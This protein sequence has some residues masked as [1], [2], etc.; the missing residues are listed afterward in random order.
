[1]SNSNTTIT[2]A[3]ENSDETQASQSFPKLIIICAAFVTIL[4]L[5]WIMFLSFE[6]RAIL[7]DIRDE[8]LY[9]EELRG[10]IMVNDEILSSSAR[11][12]VLTNDPI[13]EERYNKYASKL[14]EAL[15]KAIEL[16]PNGLSVE[17]AKKTHD[18]NHELIR[19]EETA[20]KL[21]QE[22]KTED[23]VAVLFSAEYSTQKE[24]Y[25]SG[26]LVFSEELKKLSI[27]QIDH[28]IKNAKIMIAITTCV[29]LFLIAVWCIA[30]RNIQGWQN[31][32]HFAR[33]K[34]EEAAQAKSAFL[35]NTSHEIRTPMNGIIGMTDILKDTGLNKDQLQY[36]KTISDSCDALLTIT[37]DILDF[38]KVEAGH[39]SL[40]NDP[41]NLEAALEDIVALLSQKAREK[42]LDF[43]L[44]YDPSIPKNFIGDV[45][46]LRQIITNITGNAIKFTL[47][48]YVSINVEAISVGGNYEIKIIISD[49][50]IGIPAEK[51]EGIFTAFEQVDDTAN[52]KFEG[53]GLGLAIS[54]NLAHLMGGG[55]SVTSEKDQG[56]AFT[57]SVTLAPA[58]ASEVPTTSI[59]EQDLEGANILIVDDIELNRRI[60]VSQFQKWGAHV[61]TAHN[62]KNA[63]EALTELAKK[64]QLPCVAIIDYQMPKTTGLELIQK[65]R[66]SNDF[67]SIR[68]ILY[69]SVDTIDK[70]HA[71]KMGVDTVLLKPA[72]AH[73]LHGAVLRCLATEK[74]QQAAQVENTPITVQKLPEGLKILVA[75]DNKTNRLVVK[76]YLSDHP[77]ELQ[78]AL[79]GTEAV[80]Q[81]KSFCPDIILMD[82]SMPIMNGLDATI[83]IRTDEQSLGKEPT[84]IIGLSANAL[85]SQQAQALESGMHDFITKP[86]R[87]KDLICK[88]HQY[89]KPEVINANK[90][91]RR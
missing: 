87:K 22:R 57:F 74:L 44:Y 78:F 53:T 9:A 73:F 88:L 68:N 50:G 25:S 52:R 69:S 18:A 66:T 79:N 33:K 27:S 10:T 90:V 13:W 81:A 43:M 5:S 37:N 7:E 39:I 62:A 28:E 2:K 55:V 15:E 17:A 29:L 46:R 8:S 14:E 4:A 83:H 35:A 19:M 45:G 89:A 30:Y 40:Q 51:L 75:E 76:R 11:L 6:Q 48:G 23:A 71:I 80:E 54:H 63:I 58:A 85:K 84:I 49:S 64:N 59:T 91:L 26:M 32:L 38:S 56:S 77:I 36:V 1:M 82:W 70:A 61:S 20:F 42:D 24:I 34:S 47:K 65:M 72:R 16:A 3:L 86:V 67:R 31:A 21:L 60:L 41:F 12:G